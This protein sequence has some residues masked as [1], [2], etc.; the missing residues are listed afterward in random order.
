MSAE[1]RKDQAAGDF[2]EGFSLSFCV[3]D[4]L[5]GFV[6]EYEVKRIVASICAPTRQDFLGCL[7]SYASTYWSENPEEGKAIALRFYEAG[8][9]DQPRLRDEPYPHIGNGHWRIGGVS[10][11]ADFN[12]AADT[13]EYND[14][15]PVPGQISTKELVERLHMR[16]KL[17]KPLRFKKGPA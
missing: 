13:G 12:A 11:A 17:M 4:I 8:K 15:A 9:I 10:L 14:C 1:N 6:R 3:S 5:K 7:D 2:V 16:W